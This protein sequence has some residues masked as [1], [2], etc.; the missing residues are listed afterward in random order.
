MNKKVEIN[1]DIKKLSFEE[2]LSELEGIVESLE[3][4]DIDL[5]DSISIYER[6]V[7]LKAHCESKLEK[8]KMKVD[9]IITQPDGDFSSEPLDE[10]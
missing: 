5:E 6:G 1:S 2:A 3:R 7:V 10:I 8:A 9:K 4:G